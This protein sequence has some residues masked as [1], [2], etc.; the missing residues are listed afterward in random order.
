MVWPNINNLFRKLLI[1]VYVFY[2]NSTIPEKYIT[3]IHFIVSSQSGVHNRYQCF[4]D[5]IPMHDKILNI[6]YIQLKLLYKLERPFFYF[7]C[8]IIY[9][10]FFSIWSRHY[11]T[12]FLKLSTTAFPLHIVYIVYHHDNSYFFLFISFHDKLIFINSMKLF[13]Q[14]PRYQ[15]Q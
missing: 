12:H 11:I 10:S 13:Q 8:R 5:T 9:S 6:V 2:K 3:Q 15:L 1:L 7:L 4:S 14:V